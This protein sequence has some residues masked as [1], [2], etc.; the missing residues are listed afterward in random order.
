MKVERFYTY[1][2]V[3]DLFWQDCG[4]AGVR[5]VFNN[6]FAE[7]VKANGGYGA[8]V[9]N[10]TALSSRQADAIGLRRRKQTTWYRVDGTGIRGFLVGVN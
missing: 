10:Y 7:C 2:A 9:E 1:V 8:I 6:S 5:E 4:E 3:T